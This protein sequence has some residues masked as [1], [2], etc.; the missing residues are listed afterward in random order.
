MFG[1]T[2]KL[3]LLALGHSTVTCHILPAG[4]GVHLIELVRII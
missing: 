4:A 1:V 3:H 2:F